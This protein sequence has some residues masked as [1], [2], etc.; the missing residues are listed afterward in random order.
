MKFL[1]LIFHIGRWSVG[2]WSVGRWL[3]VGG[4]L[5]RLVGGQLVGG[6]KKTREKRGHKREVV[7]DNLYGWVKRVPIPS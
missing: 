7:C 5:D 3:V 2:Q 6:F 4:W 1:V